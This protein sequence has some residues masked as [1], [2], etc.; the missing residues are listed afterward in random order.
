VWPAEDDGVAHAPRGEY[1]KGETIFEDEA[2]N[3]KFALG[4]STEI[5]ISGRKVDVRE[6]WLRDFVVFFVLSSLR[7]AYSLDC[8]RGGFFRRDVTS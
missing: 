3:K 6:T 2:R 1:F 7:L 5:W 8:S 4:E